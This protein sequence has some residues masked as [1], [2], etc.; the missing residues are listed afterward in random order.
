MTSTGLN[1]TATIAKP[2]V[3]IGA[4]EGQPL[5]AQAESMLVRTLVD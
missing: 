3:R 4:G 1:I 2:T 5:G